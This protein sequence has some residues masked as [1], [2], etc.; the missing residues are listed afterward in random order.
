[1]KR[2]FPIS[3]LSMALGAGLAA[4]PAAASGPTLF[5]RPVQRDGFHFQVAFGWGAGATSNGVFHN[6]EIGGTFRNGWSMAYN[7]VFIQ[8]DG[9][10]KPEGAPDL[11][12]GHMLAFRFPLVYRDLILRVSV[13]PG[14]THDQSDG[15][16]AHWGVAWL[17]GV[18]LH[19]PAWPTSGLTAGLVGLHVVTENDGHHAGWALSL[20]YTWF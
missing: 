20:G 1:M 18:D 15:I 10:F 19:L 4:A 2:A 16:T 3:V 13:G 11:I 8:S 6:M 12:G 5:G 9:F 7:H 17:Y 14:G